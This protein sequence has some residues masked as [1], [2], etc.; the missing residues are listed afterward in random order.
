MP[1]VNPEERE[2][3]RSMPAELVWQVQARKKDSEEGEVSMRLIIDAFWMTT[4]LTARVF[5]APLKL[6]IY[7]LSL[8]L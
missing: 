7:L 4:C 6:F 5:T 3:R 8:L 1:A 2:P